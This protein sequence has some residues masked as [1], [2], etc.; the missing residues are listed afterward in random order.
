VHNLDVSNR[1]EHDGKRRPSTALSEI[2][3]SFE[4]EQRAGSLPLDLALR[5]IALR[6]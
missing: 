2:V 3:H 4:G 1:L 6:P 5:K